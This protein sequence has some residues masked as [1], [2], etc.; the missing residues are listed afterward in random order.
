MEPNEDN[1]SY[2]EQWPVYT[3]K[4]LVCVSLWLSAHCPLFSIFLFT[5][6]KFSLFSFFLCW[7]EKCDDYYFSLHENRVTYSFSRVYFSLSLRF[8]LRRRAT[9]RLCSCAN[10]SAT[11]L[12]L[13][14]LDYIS[15]LTYN[16]IF[17][18]YLSFFQ[19]LPAQLSL[20]PR[21]YHFYK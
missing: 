2:T 21:F 7:T 8:D 15:F 19:I 6:N 11:K 5:V 10:S 18:F 20:F 16:I 14:I 9:P 12:F 13:Q 17:F 1:A 3:K 4:L